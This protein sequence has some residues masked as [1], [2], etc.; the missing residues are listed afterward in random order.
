MKKI[1]IAGG[2]YG[3]YKIVTQLIDKGIPENYQ[4]TLVD[5]HAYHSLKTEFYALASG[6][7]S[8][9]QVRMPFPEHDRFSV[10]NG[11]ILG[12]D[13]G[14]KKI[15]V[16]ELEEP[17]EY[18]YLVIALGCEDNFHGIE[19]AEEFTNSLQSL[20]KTRRTYESINN[21]D[22]DSLV[23][24]IG[25]GLTGV[26]LAA[27]LREIRPDLSIR[28]YDRGE[29]L[30]NGFP[31][32]L[33]TFVMK[34][35]TDHSIEI[36]SNS[37]IEKLEENTV[38]VNGTRE[39]SDA[40]VWTAGVQP[41]KVV[42]DID[43]EKDR[44]GRIILND[45]YQ[46]PEHNEV[47][48]VGDCASLPYAPSGQLAGKQGEQI[49]KMLGDIMNGKEVQKPEEINLKG[50]LG[51]LGKKNGFGVVYNNPLIGAVP[52]LMKSG[53]LWAHKLYKY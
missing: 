28:I 50:T 10:V 6:S 25:G 12:I 2:G 30:L 1:V 27:E 53:T 43:V 42:R 21:L 38:V 37:T 19:G 48:V 45:Y 29:K 39:H 11:E 23:S 14:N 8:D 41:V 40:I 15:Q 17:V 4:V 26:E 20:A 49:A 13:I 36:R 33:R 18:D 7:I 24:L 44:T 31:D 3:G 22:P 47:F 5:R 52:R 35:F 51:S 16:R 9:F 34:W 32:K 46:I